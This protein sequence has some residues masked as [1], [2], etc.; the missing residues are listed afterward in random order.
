[1]PIYSLED[2][3]ELITQFDKDDIESLGLVKFDILG[4]TTLTIMDEAL[5]MISNNHESICLDSISLDDQKVFDLLKNRMTTGIFQLESLGMKKYM[6]QLQPDRFED[7]VALVALY[8]PGPLGTNMVDDFIANKHGAEI[9][10][11]HPL[12]ENILSETNGLILYQE[13]VME[14]AKSLGNYTLGDADLLRRAMGKK[15]Q[16][17]MENHRSRFVDGC[18]KNKI[19]ENIARSIFDKMEK[20]AGYGFNKSHSVAYALLSYQTAYLKAYYP[21]EFFLRHYHLIWI[22]PIK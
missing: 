13:Q 15:K 19:S 18:S 12:L 11:E 17:E 2:K 16:K 8:R 5:K 20:F 6:A 1:M 7:I 21:T 14:I 9:K 22:T 10:Y 4:L 3:S